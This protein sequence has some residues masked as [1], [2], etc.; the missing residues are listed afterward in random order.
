MQCLLL[1]FVSPTTHESRLQC[2]KSKQSFLLTFVWGF[3]LFIYL[4]F[5]QDQV[6][7]SLREK[8]EMQKELDQIR[9][10]NE[11]L[12]SALLRE[13]QQAASLKVRLS[14]FPHR[15]LS[16]ATEKMVKCKLNFG[17]L[18]QCY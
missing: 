4:F 9:A 8:A 10:E 1:T 15:H 6:E 12:K 18:T 2:L 7:Q 3:F 16:C 13:Q 5:F 17:K 11:T 14:H